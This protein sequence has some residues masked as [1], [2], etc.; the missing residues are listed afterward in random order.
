MIAQKVR[1]LTTGDNQV[2]RFTREVV[3]ALGDVGGS[4]VFPWVT[5][6][7]SGSGADYITSGTSDDVVINQAI[8]AVSRSDTLSVVWLLPGSYILSNPVTLRSG[9]TL[10]G[11]GIGRTVIYIATAMPLVNDSVPAYFAIGAAGGPA[12]APATMAADATFGTTSLLLDP[13]SDMSLF[14]AD[15]YAFVVSED[16]WEISSP[17]NGRKRG[18]LVK[19]LKFG[20][21][22]NGATGT[23]TAYNTT[24][25]Y[26][27][28][29]APAATFV[30]ADVDKTITTSGAAVANLNGTWRIVEVTDATHIVIFNSRSG[31]TNATVSGDANNGA[32]AWKGPSISLTGMGT[33]D[34]YLVA[35][36]ALVYPMSLVHDVAVTDIEI[37]QVAP[38][39][40]RD[41][42]PPALGFRRCHNVRIDNVFI[43]DHDAPG[44]IL[45]SVVSGT[46]SNFRIATLRDYS[47]ANQFGYGVL[48]SNAAEGNVVGPGHI[49]QC[50][51]GIDTGRYGS[52]NDA[53]GAYGVPR[54]NTAQ[55]V[56]V[57]HATDAAFSTHTE[58]DGMAYVSCVAQNCDNFGFYMRGKN[59]LLQSCITIWCAGGYEVGATSS[60][61]YSS[62]GPNPAYTGPNH[63]GVGT[64]IIGCSATHIH[65]ITSAAVDVFGTG[66]AS[67]GGGGVPLDLVRADHCVIQGCTFDQCD[68]GIRIRKGSK[69]N[70]FKD[71][72]LLDLNLNATSAVGGSAISFDSN[73]YGTGQVTAFAGTTATFQ[74]TVVTSG[75]TMTRADIGG[76]ITIT[77]SG[78][79]NNG[80]FTILS[81]DVSV[82]PVKVTYTNAA[83]SVEAGLSW[84]EY[85]SE[86]NYF[87]NNFALNRTGAGSDRDLPGDARYFF[88]SGSG[89]S[90]QGHT[91]KNNVFKANTALN[92]TTGYKLDNSTQNFWL[93]DNA[94]TDAITIP[95]TAGVPT[96]AA[97]AGTPG[98]G[99]IV[100]DDTND[101]LY[102]RKAGGYTKK[103]ALT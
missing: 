76:D 73:A 78:A 7:P 83:G 54:G 52:V 63:L 91:S 86:N 9:V 58:S 102:V 8:E 50:R 82:S 45:D 27:S 36:T 29:T 74:L 46:V 93:A 4:S 56:I 72:L 96:D 15:E 10:K 84:E 39:G 101:N 5:V 41:N 28:F 80:T 68:R 89:G 16:V 88:R 103:V 59:T 55:H 23:F 92:M 30:D 20:A 1:P 60:V 18:E 42:A 44:V 21:D 38:A 95:T 85:Q 11:S 77:G 33:R 81:V 14:E 57:D 3:A 6:G 37:T 22:Q 70:V 49:D 94:A 40:T 25:K 87:I 2:D 65:N 35:S 99:V 79:G 69:W 71:N 51:H 100:Y 64:R 32:I 67:S 61:N 75:S 43:H 62:S 34:E 12:G 53:V 19:M 13:G 26:A 66:S 31:L 48:V 98:L 47:A 90:V 24:T 97:F 17:N